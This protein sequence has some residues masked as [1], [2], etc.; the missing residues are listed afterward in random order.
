MTPKY[1]GGS[2]IRTAEIRP[3]EAG[4]FKELI[5]RQINLPVV[6]PITREE[7][8]AK[9]E[10]ER[11]QIKAGPFI[12]GCSFVEGTT[13]RRDANADRLVVQFLDIDSGDDA[14]RFYE[15]PEVLSELLYPYSFA[16]YLTA[17]S[18][19]ENPRLR[20]M[21]DLVPCDPEHRRRIVRFIA[22]RIGIPA[23]FK[24]L[25]ES[26][27]TSQPMFRPVVFKGEK[28]YSPVLC[29]RTDGQ[30]LDIEDVPVLEPEETPERVYT[31]TGDFGDEMG[32]AF[33]P[34]RDLTVEDIVPVLDALDPDMGFEAWSHIGAAMRHQFRS[35]E[36][37]EAAFHAWDE[38]SS[39]GSKYKE[40]ETYIK[41]RSFRPD[42]KGKVPRTIRTLF[43]MAIDAGW[44]SSEFEAKMVISV[45]EWLQTKPSK[46]VL[47]SE[48]CERIVN[49]PFSS[50][51]LEDTLVTRLTAAL[52]DAMG[53]KVEKA[54]V[55]KQ[56]AALRN[57]KRIEAQGTDKPK[58]LMPFV[59]L[60]RQ[61]IFHN[62]LTGAQLI[63]EAFD[64][65]FGKELIST[66]PES[67]SAKTG[68]PAILPRHYA[69]NQIQIDRV[70]DSIY[71]PLLGSEA[72]PLVKYK[73]Q[74]YL[75]TYLPSS[76]PVMDA[77]RSKE[78]GKLFREHMKVLI[79]E[80]TERRHVIDYMCLQVQKPGVKIPWAIFIQSAEGVGK[81]FLGR[82]MM[83]VL[84]KENVKVIGPQ[85]LVNQWNDWQVGAIFSIFEEIHIPGHQREAV[86]NAIKVAV[87]DLTVPINKR[88]TSAFDAPNYTNYLGFSNFGDALHLKPT[89]R[90]WHCIQS[91]IQTEE[92]VM[93][94]NAT[95][96]FTRMEPLLD[97]LAGALRH[98]MMNRTISEDFPLQGPAPKTKYRQAIIENSKN[99]LLVEI[100]KLIADPDEP[101]IGDDV[102]HMERLIDLTR[103][104]SKNNAK[105]SH[106][107][108]SLGFEKWSGGCVK[109][110]GERTEL[111]VH[112][113][114][115]VPTLGDPAEIL[116]T[117][118]VEKDL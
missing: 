108:R 34:V 7:F 86:M 58:W 106:Y 114:R 88:N 1:W 8:F 63:P 94:L 66:D 98:W 62:L 52:T 61:N 81:G 83:A 11:N 46:E 77:K 110:A 74:L 71:C 75:N 38:W 70:H 96:H 49:L 109:V 48:G 92:Q 103:Y 82:M 22:S 19:P 64:N 27:V 95:G 16:A 20:I 85:I 51:I 31:F 105:P 41:W 4:N 43:R 10:D 56:I 42:P 5:E 78:A 13:Q 118:I 32:L 21:V 53:M 97:E 73:G 91:P 104:L 67:E 37:A 57:Q 111:Y 25:R 12:T 55:K 2:G 107:L 59:Y 3:L 89:D 47:M 9:P 117:R 113:K 115:F 100:E 102:I 18:T 39:R 65:M 35:A 76:A 28:D 68:R 26:T 79:A 101:L 54:A 24:G 84:G 40:G 17:S 15:A 116:E 87:S 80:D 50:T 33:L 69:L 99:P 112:G 6:I 36:E 14:R 29:C 90:R 45:E 44:K 93:E 23:D 72:E 60:G 30:A